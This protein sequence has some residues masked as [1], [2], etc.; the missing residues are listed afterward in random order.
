MSNL[1]PATRLTLVSATA[2]LSL[3]LASTIT[4]AQ[5]AS[6]LD[7]EKCVENEVTKQIG[8]HNTNITFWCL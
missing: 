8:K 7:C 2:A 5:S 3:L 6:D 4:F 1:N